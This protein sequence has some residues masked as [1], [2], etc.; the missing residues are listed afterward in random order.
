MLFL[1]DSLIYMYIYW[2]AHQKCTELALQSD[3]MTNLEE[4]GLDILVIH[5]LREY[6]ELLPQ[7]LVGEVDLSRHDSVHNT[8]FFNS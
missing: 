1:N 3:V 8:H 7:K 5:E 6:E 2:C 4:P